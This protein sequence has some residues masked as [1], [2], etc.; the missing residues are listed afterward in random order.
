MITVLSTGSYQVSTTVPLTV[1]DKIAVGQQATVRVNGADT[2]LNGTVASI[3]V[4]KSTA[5]RRPAPR[6]SRW[7]SS[8]I[9]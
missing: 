6:R 9:R 5:R 2:A 8:W 3:G 4:L 7:S 1:V